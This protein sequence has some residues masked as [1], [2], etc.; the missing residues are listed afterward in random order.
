MLDAPAHLG[1]AV[2]IQA[3]PND[4]FI[5]FNDA[6]RARDLGTALRTSRREPEGCLLARPL[7]QDYIHDRRNDFPR[8]LDL[9]RVAD[10]DVLLADI[11]FVVQR[12]AT[13]SAAGQENR[14][15]LGHRRERAG[16]ADLNG[17]ALEQ[18]FGLLS[19]VLVRD[20]PARRFG[21]EAGYLALRKR[22]EL[23]DS[24]VGLVGET[25]PHSVQLVNSGDQ[26]LR[27]TAM[28]GAVRCFEAEG[29]QPGEHLVVLL[30]H[31]RRALDQA[32][33]ID[34]DI[35]RTLGDDA[36]VEL[37]ER[38]GSG[39]ARIGE[40]LLTGGPALGVQLLEACLGEI[41]LAAHFQQGGRASPRALTFK[42]LPRVRAREDARPPIIQAHRPVLQ[43]RGNAANRL[44][45]GGDVVA[46]GAI[47][48]RGTAGED[49]I[50]IAE[51]DGDAVHLRIDDPLQILVGE[52]L[53]HAIHEVAHF[54]LRIGVIQAEHRQPMLH[55][56]ELLQ[57]LAADALAWGIG[58]DKLGKLLLQV[59]QLV[60]KP[61]IFAVA[62]GRL[63]E[64]VIGVVM[65]ADLLDQLGITHL[66]FAEVHPYD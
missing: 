9:H 50:L 56:L 33:A 12:G 26:F 23:D 42:E 47:A 1:R 62:D 8:L 27:R 51:V 48:A 37:L 16:A 59:Q 52:Q 19:G 15:Q 11:V 30:R 38:A 41:R 14:L 13:D 2:G 7:G 3:A 4:A 10:A 54:L 34:D 22:V 17:D 28:P 25:A 36:R 32:Q 55:L 60:I 45:V 40:L 61:V 63:R 43:P 46:G 64:H 53:L 20:G 5:A 35:Q 24:A 65:P 57:R 29:F 6:R 39:V 49:A 18:R 31:L 21:G 44:E 66:G 58:R